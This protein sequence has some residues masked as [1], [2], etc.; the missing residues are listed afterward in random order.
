[1]IINIKFLQTCGS[2]IFEVEPE[3]FEVEPEV[4]G[5]FSDESGCGQCGSVCLS[6]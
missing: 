2:L 5:D 3:T 1:M 6:R 4:L